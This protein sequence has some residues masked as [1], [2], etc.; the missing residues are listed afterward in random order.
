MERLVSEGLQSKLWAIGGGKGGVGKSIVTLLLAGWLGRLGSKVVLVDADLGGA[1]LHTLLGLRYPAATLDDF[2]QR[3]LESLDEVTLETP[4]AGVRLI[5]GADDILGLANPK[6]AQKMRLLRQLESLEAD[7]VLL[8]LG[9]GTG[10]NTL[11]FFIWSPG[12]ICVF[13]PQATS[14]QNAYGYLKSALYRH[15]N[16][17]L[18]RDPEI[19]HLIKALVSPDPDTQPIESVPALKERVKYASLDGYERLCQELAGFR[20]HLLGNM[21]RDRQGQGAAG[22]IRSVAANFLGLHAPLL[23]F[24]SYEPELERKVNDLVP[25]LTGKYASQAASS[26]YAVANQVIRQARKAA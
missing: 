12:R 26:L 5:S 19:G 23:G 10:F 8:D 1:N 13:T 4:L 24:V 9:A 17:C 22:V 20:V 3:R 18:G 7:F 25:L 11:D 15:L 2:I 14:V 21:L 6:W 16:S